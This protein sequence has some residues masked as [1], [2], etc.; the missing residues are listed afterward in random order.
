MR[1]WGQVRFAANGAT[2]PIAL[3]QRAPGSSTWVRSGDLVQVTHSQGYFRARR[4]TQRGVDLAR[5]LGLARLRQFEISREAVA[6]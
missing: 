3:Q 4:P 1:I 2:Y 5:G 6:R